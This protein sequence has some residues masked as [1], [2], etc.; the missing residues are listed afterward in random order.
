[1]PVPHRHVQKGGHEIAPLQL[2]LN[3]FQ[4]AQ[5]Q[6]IALCCQLRQDIRVRD[7]VPA[8]KAEWNVR[9]MLLPMF[10]I[11]VTAVVEEQV[12]LEIGRRLNRPI[13][14]QQRW[15]TYGSVVHL[16]TYL[17]VQACQH[18]GLVKHN[19]SCGDSLM[20]TI[21]SSLTSLPPDAGSS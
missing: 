16:V 14:Y 12:M 2:L 10:P 20:L 19:E 17:L 18:L 1:M 13:A 21:L 3:Q 5:R 9:I 4:R 8:R 15:R 11:L 7:D 6:A